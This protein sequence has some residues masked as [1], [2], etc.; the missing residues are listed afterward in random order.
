MVIDLP[1]EP[2]GLRTPP[3]RIVLR[4]RKD[5]RSRRKKRW[6]RN[7]AVKTRS[8]IRIGRLLKMHTAL[9]ALSDRA[10][11]EALVTLIESASWRV[12]AANS[13]AEARR[14]FPGRDFDV[15]FAEVPR[16]GGN[17]WFRA[18]HTC[19]LAVLVDPPVHALPG[20]A[21]PAGF[22]K[23]LSSPF[24]A[25]AVAAILDSGSPRAGPATEA[26]GDVGHEADGVGPARPSEP[27]GQ[28]GKGT[29]MLGESPAIRRVETLIRAMGP[30]T[31][32]VLITGETGTGKEVAA[33]RLHEFSRC[34]R[35]PFVAVNCG[36]LTPTLMSSQL[37]GHERGSFSGAR[38]RHRGVF[39]RADGGT[40]F[41]D[42]IT[43]ISVDLQVKFLRVLEQGQFHRTG[44][45]EIVSVTFRP[46]AATNRDPE[47]AI[48]EGRL[49]ADLYYRLAVLQL[50]VP[51]LRER[52]QDVEL[53][54]HEFL[55]E[56][57]AQEGESK[58]FA[59]GTLACLRGHS[60]PGNVRELR[61]TVH[62]AYLMTEGREITP[63]VLPPEVLR[64]V[65]VE[66]DEDGGGVRVPF[67]ASIEEVERRLI[68][69][70]LDQH[71]GNKA[72][73][74]QTLGISPKTLYNRLKSYRSRDVVGPKGMGAM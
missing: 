23:R 74:A 26:E 2:G 46:I 34:S 29:R 15:V 35:G 22:H 28:E 50:P 63:D 37:F 58:V 54:A 11:Q 25:D 18:V 55:N 43:E 1:A 7:A 14:R 32:P 13:C 71:D 52:G 12:A 4:G 36:S 47:K 72:Q 3:G 30:S 20:G 66:P 8:P 33:R 56:V 61:N 6:Y 57:I 5:R 21:L 10:K 9:V 40:L 67:G 73:T 53:L 69:L 59:P 42:E 62:S 44:G 70:T 48:E 24:D 39:E 68:F 64:G 31:A 51:P 19:R 16:E 41:L 60:W 65:P 49:R 45:E 17:G 27:G 38:R